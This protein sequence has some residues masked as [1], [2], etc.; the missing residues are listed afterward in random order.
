MPRGVFE[1]VNRELPSRQQL[2]FHIP[3]ISISWSPEDVCAFVDMVR[4]NEAIVYQH[5]GT[6]G[7][8]YDIMIELLQQQGITKSVSEITSI[9]RV[10]KNKP[11]VD[12]IS[13]QTS[14]FKQRWAGIYYFKTFVEERGLV[15]TP[16]DDNDLFHH[17]LGI[18]DGID[19]SRRLQTILAQHGFD[20]RSEGVLHRSNMFLAKHIG[21]LLHREV[22]PKVSETPPSQVSIWR[23]R[24]SQYLGARIAAVVMHHARALFSS[25]DKP[26]RH[27]FLS[28]GDIPK[29]SWPILLKIWHEVQATLKADGVPTDRILTR[30]Q[31]QLASVWHNNKNTL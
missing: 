2:H 1:G 18:E 27:T 14:Q 4:D 10:L 24:T 16:K 13:L 15:T 25:H 30:G 3:V 19:T 26:D 11:D 23:Q 12:F 8:R 7:V 28:D 22:W 6:Q 29:L 17:F 31:W 20:N 21:G 5:M 9:M